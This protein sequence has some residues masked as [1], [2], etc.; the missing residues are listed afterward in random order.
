MFAVG[1]ILPFQLQAKKAEGK[2]LFENDTVDVIFE[3]PFRPFSQEPNYMKLQY[4]LRYYDSLGEINTLKPG[5]AREIG[6]YHENVWIRMLS[7]PNTL[8]IEDVYSFKSDIFLKLELD[9]EIKLFSYYTTNSFPGAFNPSTGSSVTYTDK[10]EK[11]VLQKGNNEL[12][13]PKSLSFRKD[14]AAYFH[15]CPDLSFKIENHEFGKKDLH[16]IIRFYNSNCVN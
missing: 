3:I 8:A 4:K 16:A 5:E 2:I 14:M 10:V 13:Q 6:F 7:R 12:K 1:L 9:G 11:Y 15:D